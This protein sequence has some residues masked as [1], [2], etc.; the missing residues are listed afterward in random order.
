MAI[1]AQALCSNHKID[2]NISIV[3]AEALSSLAK[4]LQTD[5]N[6]H[7]AHSPGCTV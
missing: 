1:K 6:H 2:V 3:L 4:T 5:F 7:A